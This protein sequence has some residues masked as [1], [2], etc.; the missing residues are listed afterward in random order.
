MFS[1]DMF[2]KMDIVLIGAV[3]IA[4]AFG[5]LMIYSAGFDPVEQ[6]NKGLYKKQ[7]IW[8]IIGVIFM[9][10][11]SII[12]Y[13]QLGDYSLHV[14]GV[15][16]FLVLVTTIFGRPI[17]GTSAWLDFGFFSIQPSEF[18][19]L[20]V[21]IVLAKYLE[22]RERDIKNFR[23]LLVPTLVTLVPVL[24][25][26]KQPDF[27]TAA[28]FIPVLFTMLFMGGADVS[29]LISIIL[30]A[31]IALV[32]PMMYTYLE[33][34]GYKGNSIIVQMFVHLDVLFTISG[35]LLFIAVSTFVMHFFFNQKFLRKIYIPATV[36]SLG[37]MMSVVIHKWFKE[38]QKKRILVFLNPDLDPHGSGYN[39]IQSKVAI[40]SGGIFGKGFLQ[41]TQTQLG[42]LPEKTSDFIFPVIAEELGFIGAIVAIFILGL[43]IYRGME[44]ALGTRDKF[45]AL[46]ATGITAILFFHILINI[47]MVIGIM[48]VTG[49]PLCF[50]SYG[51]SNLF[52]VMIGVGILNNISMNRALY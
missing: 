2:G 50:F 18:M 32:F 12:N 30:I 28:I 26:L 49:L 36:I 16:L 23:E 40:G 5:I 46:L 1:K 37:L 8:F 15:I 20:A 38:Y 42:F 51:G 52:M 11:M 22:L 39:I 10:F 19:K 43:I 21:V 24:I 27:G 29:H 34:A 14:Y 33:W 6:I 35:V 13:R 44:I 31:S 41:G 48:P 45:G 47:G 17:R 3:F 9:L 7:I 4:V 25:I